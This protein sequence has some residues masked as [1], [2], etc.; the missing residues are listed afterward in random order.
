MSEPYWMS[1]KIPKTQA[2]VAPETAFRRA[3]MTLGSSLPSATGSA[4]GIELSPPT[5]VG[6]DALLVDVLEDD[7]E[8][9][10]TREVLE[11]YSEPT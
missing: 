6:G 2:S 9:V 11:R 1:P 4:G 10:E 5:T 3:L 8:E 7:D